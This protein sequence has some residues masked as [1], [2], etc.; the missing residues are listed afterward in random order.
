MRRLL[1]IAFAVAVLAPSAHAGL[2]WG[3]RNKTKI[4][5]NGNVTVNGCPNGQCSAPR[6]VVITAQPAPA[7]SVVV[8]PQTVL[9]RIPVR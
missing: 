8:R 1:L 3:P 4:I 7:A 6:P 9:I 2:F 5:A